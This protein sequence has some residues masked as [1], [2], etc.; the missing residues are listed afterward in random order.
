[1][2]ALTIP[3]VSSAGLDLASLG[4]G[5]LLATITGACL[6][7]QRKYPRIAGMGAAARVVAHVTIGYFSFG[8]MAFGA[9]AA[10]RQSLPVPG[11]LA[12]EGGVAVIGGLAACIIGG[13][14][15]I[16]HA[17]QVAAMHRDA[18]PVPVRVTNGQG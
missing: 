4:W 12:W 2:E 1:M 15:L 10:A 6:W 5:L 17:M 3:H 14:T 8:M 13:T 11:G 18:S 16:E 7:I 9:A